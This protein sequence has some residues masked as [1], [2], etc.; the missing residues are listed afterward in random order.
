[1]IDADFYDKHDNNPIIRWYSVGEIVTRV[2]DPDR[3]GMVINVDW[4]AR[5]WIYKVH[6]DDKSTVDTWDYYTNADL[7]RSAHT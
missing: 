6:W 2:D 5:Q 7:R 1:M 4:V 3:T